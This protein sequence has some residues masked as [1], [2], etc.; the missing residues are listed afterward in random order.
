MHETR[1]TIDS[2][3]SLPQL[4]VCFRRVLR[5]FF[6]VGLACKAMYCTIWHQGLHMSIIYCELM[7]LHQEKR[8]IAVATAIFK[9]FTW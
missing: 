2:A 9:G 7:I 4:F 8:W 1:K 3:Y 6:A 5:F